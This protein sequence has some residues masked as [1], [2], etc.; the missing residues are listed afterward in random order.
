MRDPFMEAVFGAIEEGSPF[1][2]AVEAL[3]E[4]GMVV[5]E[6][7]LDAA[8]EAVM[9]ELATPRRAWSGASLALLPLAAAAAGWVMVAGLGGVAPRSDGP[10]VIT[11]APVVSPRGAESA[12]RAMAQVTEAERCL[13][14]L[15]A[16]RVEEGLL[17]F[18]DL[19]EEG[20]L[21]DTELRRL[22]DALHGLASTVSPG[23]PSSMQLSEATE[24]GY[25]AWL[26]AFGD[27][28]EAG[29]VH[30][31]YGSLLHQS[32]R[33]AEAYTE[34]R[35]S[36]RKGARTP[37]AS[38]CEDQAL[39][40]AQQMVRAQSAEEGSAGG[41]APAK[42]G[43]EERYVEA[44]SQV[45]SD[46]PDHPNGT[47]LAY[48]AAYVLYVSGDHEHAIEWFQDVIGRDPL[49]GQAKLSS[50][51]IMDSYA[52]A[53]DWAGLEA[54]ALAF[55][56]DEEVGDADDRAQ[57]WAIAGRAGRA[58]LERD[59]DADGWLAW[60]DRYGDDPDAIQSA[61]VALRAEERDAEADAL[62]A[63]AS[64]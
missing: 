35:A 21:E 42:S 34:Y 55:H 48:E 45:L 9:A 50:H 7:E 33:L 46:N 30:C 61:V 31:A 43:W 41:G 36:S 53:E 11:A 51:L 44:V 15:Q 32:G 12:P 52:Q 10:D 38:G 62:E 63:L 4:E 25:A 60:L 20:A 5:D 57:A 16:G 24:R 2:D 17:L 40:I 29:A 64:D 18:D 8:T 26:E 14:A 3:R 47:G 54:W 6:A 37:D 27:S 22:I 23:D 39:S 13:K 28:P 49:S 56:A 59:G 1:A 19:L 58:A